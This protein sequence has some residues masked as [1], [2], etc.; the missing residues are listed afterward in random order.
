MHGM[1]QCRSF[2]T[3]VLSL[4]V[5]TVCILYTRS[6]LTS[7]AN[8][9]HVNTSSWPSIVVAGIV[10]KTIFTVFK[11]VSRNVRSDDSYII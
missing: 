8:S 5:V 4:L 9:L 3:L 10:I 6:K 11:M 2:C 1:I 7:L